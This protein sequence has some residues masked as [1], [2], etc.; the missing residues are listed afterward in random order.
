MTTIKDVAVL[1]GVSESTVSR[2]VNKKEYVKEDTRKRVYSAINQLGYKPS[3]L[4][5]GLRIKSSQILGLIISDIQNPFFTSLV[6]AVEDVTYHH[7][8]AIILC[9][10]DEDPEKEALLI[11]LMLSER[12]AGVIIT[13]TREYNC[14]L[15]KLLDKKIPVVCVDR[16]VRDFEIDTV[17][18][19]NQD[20][21]YK[22]VS[23]LIDNGH[24]R[25]GALLGPSKITSFSE[26]LD[27]FIRAHQECGLSIDNAIIKQ[28]IPK[29]N[30]GYAFTNDLLTLSHPPS[31]IFAG[32]N[33]LALGAITAIKEK[34]LSIPEDIS[35]VSFDDQEWTQLMT[36]KISVARQPTYE[37]G[38]LAAELTF[39]R[40]NDYDC[41]VNHV[42]LKSEL[43]FRESV[44]SFG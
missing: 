14:P 34:G 28:G 25:I 26:R 30:E 23:H 6:R 20:S 16:R 9:N 11:D 19:D 21:S 38:K 18:S 17:I 12:V 1:A 10:T 7:N 40:I 2:V 36:P 42:I 37:M 8:Y 31:S 4:A 44:K 5:R 41:E 27:G 24:I 32:N 3:R 13:P 39:H 22:L 15:K 43:I 29:E 33:L 35:I